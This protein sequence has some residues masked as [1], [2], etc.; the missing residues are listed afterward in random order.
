MQSYIAVASIYYRGP[1]STKKDELFDHIAQSY[2]FLMAKYGTGLQFIIA[3]D[4]NRLNLSPIL[5]LSPSLKQ[6]VRTPSRLNPPAMLDPVITT[7]KKFYSEPITKPPLEN[8]EDKQGKPSDHL[9]VLMY[10]INSQIGCPQRQTRVV[11]SRPLLQSG[12]D[13]MGSWITQQTWSEIYKCKDVNQKAKILQQ[14]MTQKMDEC[15][16]IKTVKFTS[17]DKP[18]ASQQIK[19][20]DRKCKQE[21]FKNQKSKKW[22]TLKQVLAER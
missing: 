3:G 18:W 4:T 9:V 15:F 21:F 10:P 14:M 22:K 6:M 7:M 11:E 5:N 1:K 8:D 13:K 20:L 2:H 19:E 17:D 16:P 12:I